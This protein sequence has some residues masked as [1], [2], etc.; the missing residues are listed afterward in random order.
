MSDTS[1]G[2]DWELVTGALSSHASSAASSSADGGAEGGGDGAGEGG[3]T[4]DSN[5]GSGYFV[6]VPGEV[7]QHAEL[8][9]SA[10]TEQFT[11]MKPAGEVPEVQQP[12]DLR[13][14]AAFSV[15]EVASKKDE[16]ID[17][18]RGI[19]M[20]DSCTAQLH[21]LSKL[22]WMEPRPPGHQLLEY[23]GNELGSSSNTDAYAPEIKAGL[24]PDS[25]QV[26]PLLGSCMCAPSSPSIVSRDNSFRLN[27]SDDMV[28]EVLGGS[29]SQRGFP[30]EVEPDTLASV[31]HEMLLAH[32]AFMS[33][34]SAAAMRKMGSASELGNERATETWWNRQAAL[35]GAHG[36]QAS[37]YWSIAL[38]AAVMGLVILGHRWQY[39]RRQ[40]QQLRLRLCAK[41]EKIG[42]LI[43]QLARMK[44]ALSGRRRVPVLRSNSYLND[45]FDRY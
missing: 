6:C 41:E 18:A 42:Q 35:R 25:Q 8:L 23:E 32:S 20:S 29:A 34:D 28:G 36:R 2:N 17:F 38:A 22:D 14:E 40:N 39:E 26:G 27:L 43:L 21:E 44:E 16:E 13:E 45:S 37:T 11:L 15:G 3:G 5:V 1:S 24:E 33:P 19:M 10:V 31:E 7:S 9:D 4:V 12:A 30:M